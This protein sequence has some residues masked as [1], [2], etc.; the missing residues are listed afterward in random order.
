MWQWSR[1]VLHA[2]PLYSPSVPLQV[3][4]DKDLDRTTTAG[5]IGPADDI[6]STSAKQ[7]VSEQVNVRGLFLFHTGKT[8]QM[9]YGTIVYGSLRALPP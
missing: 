4:G 3:T 8:C 1:S 2:V 6:S 5:V 9:T 7:A